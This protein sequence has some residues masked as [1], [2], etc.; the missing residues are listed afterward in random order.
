MNNKMQQLQDAEAKEPCVVVRRK[1]KGFL[2]LD[3]QTFITSGPAST[4]A[5]TASLPD[6]RQCEFTFQ[7]CRGCSDKQWKNLLEVQVDGRDH[8]IAALN[9]CQSCWDSNLEIAAAIKEH[10]GEKPLYTPSAKQIC[11]PGMFVPIIQKKPTI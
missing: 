9:F 7:V 5:V 3:D 8:H 4:D 6:Y 2:M 1:R 11:V 10:I